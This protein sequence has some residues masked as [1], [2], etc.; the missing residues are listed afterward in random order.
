MIDLVKDVVIFKQ[1][2][3]ITES[4]TSYDKSQFYILVINTNL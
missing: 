4:H 1:N 3:V 2:L